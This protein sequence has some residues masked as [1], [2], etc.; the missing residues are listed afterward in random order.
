MEVFQKNRK[1]RDS[2]CA[3]SQREIF[4]IL[5]LEVINFWFSQNAKNFYKI[6]RRAQV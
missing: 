1:N 3:A 2:L 4:A 5:T 6:F